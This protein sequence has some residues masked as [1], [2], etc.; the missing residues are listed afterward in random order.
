MTLRAGQPLRQ[1][2]AQ[3]RARFEQRLKTDRVRGHAD[4]GV[5]VLIGD[6]F[7]VA[8]QDLMGRPVVTGQVGDEALHR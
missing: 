5:A 1:F 4:E 3:A 8:E 6:I 7:V 2:G